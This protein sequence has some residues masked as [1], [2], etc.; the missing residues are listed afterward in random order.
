MVALFSLPRNLEY[1][2]TAIRKQLA[3]SFIYLFDFLKISSGESSDLVEAIRYSIETRRQSPVVFARYLDLVE[4]VKANE[5]ERALELFEEISNLCRCNAAFEIAPFSREELGND[6]LRFPQILFTDDYGSQPIIAAPSVKFESIRNNLEFGLDLLSRISP[7]LRSEIELLWT[8][9]YVGEL[10]PEANGRNFAGVTSFL[11]WGATFINAD[12][13]RTVEQAVEF[14]VH[15]STHSLLSALSCEEPLVLNRIEERYP[16]PLRSDPRPMDGIYHATLV[17]A[18]IAWTLNTWLNSDETVDQETVRSMRDSS[19][20]AFSDG[21]HTIR[22]HAQM[23][24]L[25]CELLSQASHAMDEI[26]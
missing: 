4:L 10:N 11:L 15:E 26:V 16:S 25:G 21:S 24:S 9:I 14:L 8:R 2:E 23:S 20:R 22:D 1:Y 3:D 18:R 6:Y 5:E 17:S 7:A 13:Y 19:R 12:A